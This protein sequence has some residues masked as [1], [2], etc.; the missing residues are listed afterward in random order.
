MD[1]ADL[2]EKNDEM[3]GEMPCIPDFHAAMLTART[4]LQHSALLGTSLPATL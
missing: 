1:E 2:S 3:R 4:L